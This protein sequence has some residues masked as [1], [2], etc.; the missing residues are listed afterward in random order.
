MTTLAPQPKSR[1]T[2]QNEDFNNAFGKRII[3]KV[4]IGSQSNLILTAHLHLVLKIASAFSAFSAKFFF[5]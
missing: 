3:T 2:I 4:N 1:L 5:S